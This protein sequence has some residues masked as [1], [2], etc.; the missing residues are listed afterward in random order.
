[1]HHGAVGA[2]GWIII[3][4]DATCKGLFTRNF[5]ITHLDV[6]ETEKNKSQE[7]PGAED[8]LKK[9]KGEKSGIPFWLIFDKNG[10]LI[11]SS[12]DSNDKNLGCPSTE[13]EVNEFIAILK[14][15][16]DL[17]ESELETVKNKF[18]IKE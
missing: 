11:S 14:K 7:N 18:L 2:N 13:N 9:Y 5:V 3:F 10:K 4:N 17:K 8:L 16:T 15:T 1:M 12:I 6:L